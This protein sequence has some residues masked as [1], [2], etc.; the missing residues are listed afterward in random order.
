MTTPAS[1][2]NVPPDD[3]SARSDSSECATESPAFSRVWETLTHLEQLVANELPS[4]ADPPHLRAH[5]TRLTSA[6]R[7]AEA[8]HNEALAHAIELAKTRQE[9]FEFSEEVLDELLAVAAEFVP[10]GSAAN[11]QTQRLQLFASAFKNAREGIAILDARACI[12]E[13]NPAF[14]QLTQQADNRVTG[15][16]LTTVLEWGFP[17]YAD[18]LRAVSAGKR[19][20]GQVVISHKHH[21]DRTCLLSFSPIRSNRRVANIVVIFSDITSIDQSRRQLHRLALHDQLTGLPNRRYY[22]EQIQAHINRCRRDNSAF[23]IGFLDLDNFKRINDSLGHVAADKLLRKVAQRLQQHAGEETFIARFGGDEF[24]MLIPRTDRDLRK[25]AIIADRVLTGLRTPIVVG[26][27]QATIA[28]SLGITQFPADCNDIDQLLQNADIAMYAAKQA[29]GDQTCIFAPEMRRQIEQRNQLQRALRRALTDDEIS[30]KY[31]P[32]IDLKTGTLIGCEALARWRT[33]DGRNIM[34]R[35]FLPIADTSGLVVPL[36]ERVLKEACRQACLWEDLGVRPPQLAVNI[37]PRHLHSRDFADR[38]ADIFVESGA[39]PEWFV[40]EFT[41]DAVV[42]DLP[43][44]IRTMDALVDLGLTLAIDD[45]G[46]GHASFSYL[47]RFNIHCLKIDPSFVNELASDR[48]TCAIVESMIHLGQGRQ[49]Q[50]VAEGIETQQQFE[51]LQQL[52][53]D[54]G[55]GFHIAYP[56]RAPAL[57]TWRDK[58]AV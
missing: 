46:T 35:E 8:S 44:A 34:P 22:C 23:A 38:I 26:G 7:E 37:S 33:P 2:S 30:L 50:I 14:M 27:E 49:L 12:Q 25:T 32:Q 4:S 20:T 40:L 18:V 41:E 16:P 1:L 54:I 9:G 43:H 5:V 52:G 47:K 58:T 29:G 6:V 11:Q 48:Q 13:C 24:A 15:R 36:G 3:P 53:C 56:M 21:D 28:A 57:E 45:F 17:E 19:W 10:A 39:R 55:Q 42:F 51:V 31:Q